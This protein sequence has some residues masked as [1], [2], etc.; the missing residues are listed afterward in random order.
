MILLQNLFIKYVR[1]G[2]SLWTEIFSRNKIDSVRPIQ[3]FYLRA[4]SI[5]DTTVSEYKLIGTKE[6]PV[7]IYL[8]KT[9]AGWKDAI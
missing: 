1:L 7:P 4:R 5:L 9:N 3:F 8:P 6:C 2:S